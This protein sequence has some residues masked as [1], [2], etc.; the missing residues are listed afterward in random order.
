MR[1]SINEGPQNREE[2]MKS[3]DVY[4]LLTHAALHCKYGDSLAEDRTPDEA[5]LRAAE[6]LYR[7]RTEIAHERFVKGGN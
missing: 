1:A 6:I 5:D 4:K 2:L 3:W 7:L